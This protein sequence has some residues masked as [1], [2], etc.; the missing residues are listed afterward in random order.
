MNPWKEINQ[1]FH[2][3]FKEERIGYVS[4]GGEILPAIFYKNRIKTNE[5][6]VHIDRASELYSFYILYPVPQDRPKQPKLEHCPYPNCLSHRLE[7]IKTIAEKYFVH[8][9]AC[10]ANGP[11][12]DSPEQAANRHNSIPR[13]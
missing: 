2:E 3:D 13:V 7:I 9:K 8:C 4:M 1:V 12:S 11:L 5:F 6:D 10:E